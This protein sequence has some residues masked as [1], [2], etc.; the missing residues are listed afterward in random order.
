M[1]LVVTGASGNVGTAFLRAV[2]SS[3]PEWDV[4][5]VVRR[6]P[7]PD[8]GEPYTGVDWHAVDLS[9]PRAEERLRELMSGADAVVHFAW[10]IMPSRDPALLETVNVAGSRQV[11]R[12]A[13]H[14]GVPHLVHMSSV[15]TYAPV[16]RGRLPKPVTDESWSNDGIPT[17][18]YSR[19]KAAVEHL[20]DEFDGHGFF[21]TVSRVRPG[22]V[23][24]PDAGA[25]IGR[26]F[27]G[28]WAPAVRLVRGAVPVLPLPSGLVANVVHADDL[29]DA[30]VRIV[31]RRAPGAFNI[32]ADDV[33][34]PEVLASAFRARRVPAPYAALRALVA[35][36]WRTHLQPTD[37]GWLD[38]ARGVPLMDTARAK[39]LLG[40]APVRSGAD[41]LASLVAAVGHGTGG[42]SPI[43][44]PR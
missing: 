43:L 16:P 24:Q 27:V 3:H 35:S 6:P 31:D 10:A 37:P 9:S 21:E 14:A 28:L 40:W 1:R 18:L 22:L 13:A 20:L 38:L 17:S 2:R 25:E 30:I 44:A 36:S 34:T 4:A 11:F 26:Y 42:D 29:G 32:A 23:L 7:E 19:Q 5:G 41:A 39:S 33:V 12:A 15:G 8:A